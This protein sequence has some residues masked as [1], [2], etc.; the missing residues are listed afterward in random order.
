MWTPPG[1]SAHLRLVHGFSLKTRWI[2]VVR[3]KKCL[4]VSTVIQVNLLMM[5]SKH[6]KEEVVVQKSEAPLF[7]LLPPP[8]DSKRP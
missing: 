4:T 7:L 2:T 6:F 3:V 8:H 1:I 5:A